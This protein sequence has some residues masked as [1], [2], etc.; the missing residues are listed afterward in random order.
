VQAGIV[1]EE[2]KLYTLQDEQMGTRILAYECSFCGR[3]VH[4]GER[5][6]DKLVPPRKVKTKVR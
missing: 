3:R 6:G 2:G 5:N 1:L 4:F